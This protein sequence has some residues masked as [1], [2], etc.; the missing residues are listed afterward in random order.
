MI[1]WL[2]H[3]LA[4]SSGSACGRKLMVRM[5]V[6]P[7]ALER[8][9]FGKVAFP[10]TRKGEVDL[11]AAWEAKNIFNIEVV[12]SLER[13]TC[14][15]P[16]LERQ[17]FLK[18]NPHCYKSNP[19]HHTSCTAEL[20][21]FAVNSPHQHSSPQQPLFKAALSGLLFFSTVFSLH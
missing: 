18:G 2:V 1:L 17:S 21:F 9:Y 14:V 15:K 20:G 7:K 4:I 10:G 11:T 13:S 12:S 19:G 3:M 5:D 6:P 16:L 8:G